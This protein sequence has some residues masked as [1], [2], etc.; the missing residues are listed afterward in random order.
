LADGDRVL[1]T[2]R[3]A[4]QLHPG[5]WE[6]PG[7]KIEPGEH[8]EQA[9]SREVEE[10]LGVCVE[11]GRIW[12]VLSYPYPDFDVLILIYHCRLR[13]GE[14]PRCREVAELAWLP[15]AAL[16][17]MAILQA[18]LPL[19]ARLNQEGVPPFAARD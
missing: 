12:E 14:M 18:D 11:V 7:G 4:D 16:A 10:E 2:R 5:E 9:L 15:P 17:D 8:P 3:R 13:D 19:V 1:V 6:F